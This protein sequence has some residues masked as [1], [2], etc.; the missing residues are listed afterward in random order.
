MSRRLLISVLLLAA[1]A[2][3][4]AQTTP[5][6]PALRAGADSN[7]AATLVEYGNMLI[8]RSDAA[9]AADAFYWATRLDP[10][11]AEAHYGRYVALH[12]S[13]P[14]RLASYWRGSRKTLRDKEVQRI[15]SMYS[16]AL[17]LSPTVVHRHERELVL[18]VIKEDIESSG[19]T[20]LSL[21]DQFELDQALDRWLKTWS[22]AARARMAY[23]A[24]DYVR[25][26]ELYA[27]A[28]NKRKHESAELRAA[29]GRILLQLGLADSAIHE[30]DRALQELRKRDKDELIYVYNS[31]ALLELTRGVAHEQRNDTAGARTAYGRALEEDLSYFPAHVRLGFLAASAGDTA[32]AVAELGLAVQLR[33]DDGLLRQQNGV[34]LQQAGR[35]QEAAEQ[36]SKAV[37]LEPFFAVPYLFLAQ[38]YEKLGKNADAATA[39]RSFLSNAS[40]TAPRRA[41]ASARLS[42]LGGGTN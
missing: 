16:Y 11:V 17:M 34:I 23:A 30:F 4:A 41:E 29:R 5:K 15:D 31:K 28:I 24:R 25:A 6:R 32:T 20:P 38:C 22:A 8:R 42:A 39:Y 1:A 35:F 40:R 19:G 3:V 14:R 21:G 12:M 13:N 9:G 26:L 37:E 18:A 10:S 2:D 36:F 33:P 27:I 7:D